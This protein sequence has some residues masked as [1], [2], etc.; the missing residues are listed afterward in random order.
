MEISKHLKVASIFLIAIGVFNLIINLP[1]LGEILQYSKIGYTGYMIGALLALVGY[2]IEILVGT[3]TLVFSKKITNPQIY[4]ILGAVALG[5]IVLSNIIMY[6]SYSEGL[7]VTKILSG[8]AFP[9]L[10]FF[11]ALRDKSQNI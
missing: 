4:V 10:Y 6:I 5:V 3:G 1:D 11:Y 2:V 8:V 7:R 9:V